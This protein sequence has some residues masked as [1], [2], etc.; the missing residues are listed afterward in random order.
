MFKLPK[1]NQYD[2]YNVFV[3]KLQ[4]ECELTINIK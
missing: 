2:F 1:N 3:L 4:S